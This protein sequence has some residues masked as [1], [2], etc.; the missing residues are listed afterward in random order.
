MWG[1]VAA[2]GRS[3]RGSGVLARRERGGMGPGMGACGRLRPGGRG[4]APGACTRSL[5]PGGPGPVL[6]L[7]T[8]GR[9][10][11]DDGPR[12]GGSYTVGTR[13]S[14]RLLRVYD[15]AA[16]SEGEV[17]AIRIELEC[18]DRVA[19]D[20][21][22]ALSTALPDARSVAAARFLVGFID[23]R[24]V[25]QGATVRQR[26]RCAWWG[27]L[28]GEASKAKL[29]P[30]Q[31]LSMD[32]WRRDFAQRNSSG[33]RMLCDL[34]DGDIWKSAREL[35]MANPRDNPRHRAWHRQ[36]KED[37]KAR[38]DADRKIDDGGASTP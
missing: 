18:K 36:R 28:A 15:K 34:N 11:E 21:M 25:V 10:I 27:A 31:R 33:F 14:N 13:E 22:R 26:P 7:P 8:R 4:R 12:G 32:E 6:G 5:V 3:R 19:V 29:T 17:D 30:P 16:E 23:F 1:E 35:L 38:R 2:A 9:A 24:Q 37:R 20:V